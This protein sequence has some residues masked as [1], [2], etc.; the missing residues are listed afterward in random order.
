MSYKFPMLI[1]LV[2]LLA[3]LITF[4]AVA[5][6]RGS[7][8][9]RVNMVTQCTSSSVAQQLQSLQEFHTASSWI[10]TVVT[11]EETNC[12]FRVPLGSVKMLYVALGEVRAGIDLSSFTKEDV[13]IDSAIHLRLPRSKI[14]SSRLD[15]DRSYVYDVRRSTLLAPDTVELQS[16]AQKMALEKVVESAVEVGVIET[17]DENAVLFLERFL[18]AASGRDVVIEFE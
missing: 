11:T 17:A 9:T 13:V 12:Q 1:L 5:Y 14:L 16:T 2:I 4:F 6:F 8:A 18:E 7:K 15:L 3:G 10:Q